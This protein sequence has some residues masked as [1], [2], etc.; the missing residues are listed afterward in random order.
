LQKQA[1][2]FRLSTK[3]E[4]EKPN[5]RRA[6]DLMNA[7][8]MA[9]LKELPD[10]NFA[11]GVSDEFRYGTRTRPTDLRVLSVS[12]SSLIDRVGFLTDV[13]G[14]SPLPF[15]SLLCELSVLSL[16]PARS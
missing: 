2:S 11:Y 7:A 6:L 5:D 14:I 4:F 1:N 10:I 9:V 16:S 13:K 8:A 15:T 12:A 3:Y